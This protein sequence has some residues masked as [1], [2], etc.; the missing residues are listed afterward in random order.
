M[1]LIFTISVG[2]PEKMSNVVEALSSVN[3]NQHF[4]DVVTDAFVK[5]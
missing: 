5:A 1:K 4:S 3:V 2:E